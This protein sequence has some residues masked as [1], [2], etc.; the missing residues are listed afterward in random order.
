MVKR[1]ILLALLSVA[2]GGCVVSRVDPG[3]P[4]LPLPDALPPPSMTTTALP[5]P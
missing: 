2:L 5:D 1:S 4:E 3:A